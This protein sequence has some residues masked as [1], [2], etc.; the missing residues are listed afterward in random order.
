MDHDGTDERLLD[1]QVAR[2]EQERL[3]LPATKTA[4]GPDEVLVGDD[5]ACRRVIWTDEHEIARIPELVEAS[6]AVGSVRSKGSSGSSP[7]T[8]SVASRRSPPLPKT[9]GPWADEWPSTSSTPGCATRRAIRSGY[10]RRDILE[11][12]TIRGEREV[13]QR[14]VAGRA[15]HHGLLVGGSLAGVP[16]PG[17]AAGDGRPDATSA[18]ELAQDHAAGPAVFDIRRREPDADIGSSIMVRTTSSS[19]SPYVCEN[20]SPRLWPW[21][22]RTTSR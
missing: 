18:A 7:V 2:V 15:D 10:S 11:V 4:V 5:L 16:T 19:D 22:D 9:T 12:G 13:Q 3:F 17:R 8:T 21:S 6:Q 14:E 1:H 20:G